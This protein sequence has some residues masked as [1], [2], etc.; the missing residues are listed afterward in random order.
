[1]LINYI[2]LVII[3]SP[4]IW[5]LLNPF[6]SRRIM[7]NLVPVICAANF[8]LIMSIY[9]YIFSGN[10]IELTIFNGLDIEL[11]FSV[12]SF[13]FFMGGISVFIWILSS[14]YAV[15]YQKQDEALGR[16]DTFSLL[17]L[18][19]MLGIVFSG[20][21]FTLYIFFELLTIASAVLI[22]HSQTQASLKAGLL[23]I[24]CGVIG[25]MILLLVIIATYNYTGTGDLSLI[26]AGLKNHPALP[27]IFW[28]YIIGFGIKAGLFPFHIWLPSAHPV[29]PSPASAL[30][31]GIMIKAGAYGIIKVIYNIFGK[32]I[33]GN[34]HSAMMSC[35]LILVLITIL[36][37]SIIAVTQIDIKR[38]LAY[39]SISQIGC[40]TMGAVLLS[41]SG[42]KGA[43]LY[44]F[45]HALIKS[46]LFLCAGCFIKKTGL[47]EIPGLRGIGRKMP[48]TT[49]CFTISA[50]SIIGI[51]PLNGFASKWLLAL[52][53][54]EAEKIG[55][56]Y[57]GTGVICL[58]I[59]LI[60]SF[61]GLVYYSPLVIGGWFGDKDAKKLNL[62]AAISEEIKDGN[63][64]M[65]IPIVILTFCIIFFG[66][67]P[68]FPMSMVEKMTAEYF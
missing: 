43:F 65:I 16:Y 18:S 22:F 26:G 54:L 30:H 32:E 33:L 35:F 14:V 10:I 68:K 21:L 2:P 66:I 37:G 64:W 45:N 60:S 3:I 38:M 58:V 40:I 41:P 23:Y 61:L 27:Y 52:G 7:H 17:S 44:I 1:M 24:F 39:S 62:S 20:N 31:S 4:A 55:F 5:F 51:P 25:G 9:P 29:A 46:N 53:A 15:E 67:Y 42:L 47:K 63:L 50:L 8:L 28:G 6:L 49:F 11:K 57:P 59:L 34:F 48:V 36:F 12:D 19:G 56:Y 13:N